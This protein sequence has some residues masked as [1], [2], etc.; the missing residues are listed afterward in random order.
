MCFLTT[1]TK[2]LH[3]IAS[4]EKFMCFIPSDIDALEGR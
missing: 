1:E 3:I 4:F 2:E